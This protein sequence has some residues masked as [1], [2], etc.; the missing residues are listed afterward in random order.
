MM[1]DLDRARCV[2]EFHKIG[3][4][5]IDD[6]IDSYHPKGF[7]GRLERGDVT[8]DDFYDYVRRSAGRDI[9]DDEIRRAF[10][11]FLWHPRYKLQ[12][13]RTQR[14]RDSGPVPLQHQRRGFPFVR[15]VL[16]T[17]EGLQLDDYFEKAYLSYE[18]HELKPS[19]KFTQNDRKERYAPRSDALHRRQ[20]GK[21]S[22]GAGTGIPRIYAPAPRRFQV[23]VRRRPGQ[24]IPKT[25]N[26]HPKRTAHRCDTGRTFGIIR[27]RLQA[28]RLQ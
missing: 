28:V 9:A 4:T 23:S 21:S 7:L 14:E 12:M 26:R 15:D 5:E 1:I 10:T 25:E 20:C 16:F 13:V 11:S 19:P 24:M 27:N 17:Q 6:L 22:H 18:M 8:N 3:F 2:E